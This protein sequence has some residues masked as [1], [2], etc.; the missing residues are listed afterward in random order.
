MEV[1]NQEVIQGIPLGFILCVILAIIGI[2]IYMKVGR[3]HRTSALV[4]TIALLTA[5]CVESYFYPLASLLEMIALIAAYVI[6]EKTKDASVKS[7]DKNEWVDSS[8]FKDQYQADGEAKPGC[9]VITVYDQ[10]VKDANYDSYEK[11]YV[12]SSRNINKE[13]FNV[14]TNKSI[15]RA[16]E[17]LQNGKY[18]YVKV[19]PCTEDNMNET[20]ERLIRM[21]DGIPYMISFKEAREKRMQKK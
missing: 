18:A 5:V 17:D 6:S 21:Y 19:L 4:M 11:A 3:H 7:S 16:Y 14:L 10:P 2:I 9:Y 15:S 13:V 1:L 12:G 20:Q 8:A